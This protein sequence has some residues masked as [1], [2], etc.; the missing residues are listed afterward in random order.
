MR[1]EQ[2]ANGKWY[3]HL[4]EGGVEYLRVVSTGRM[5]ITCNIYDSVCGEFVECQLYDTNSFLEDKE[6]IKQPLCTMSMEE[7]EALLR[8]GM[9]F[10][11]YPEATGSY[12]PDTGKNIEGKSDY[13]M[14]T[15]RNKLAQKPP[16]EVD[17]D[18]GKYKAPT[19]AWDKQEGGSHYKEKGVEPLELTLKNKGYEAFAGACYCKVSKYTTRDKESEVVDLKKAR[20]VLDIWIEEA[21]K[22]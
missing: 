5:N 9:L 4:W 19:S 12:I 6:L 20:H 16:T 18:W 10:S 3:E 21:S 14:D 7:Y 8:S 2:I 13:Y 11:L 1:V 15:G 22:L 17:I